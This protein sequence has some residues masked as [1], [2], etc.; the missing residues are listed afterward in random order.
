[1]IARRSRERPDDL[2]GDQFRQEVQLIPR[3]MAAE[4]HSRNERLPVQGREVAGRLHLARSSE[5]G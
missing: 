4:G 5:Y 3:G 2:R 1:M